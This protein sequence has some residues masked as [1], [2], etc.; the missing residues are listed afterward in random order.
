[1]RSR[2]SAPCF[3]PNLN[4]TNAI[5]ELA[6]MGK[7]NWFFGA[8]IFPMTGASMSAAPRTVARA[9]RR[10]SVRTKT[11][12]AVRRTRPACIIG[13]WELGGIAGRRRVG[14]ETASMA[15]IAI[16]GE[17]VAIVLE[18]IDGSLPSVAVL[19]F[20]RLIAA[21]R[22]RNERSAT[23]ATRP[24]SRDCSCTKKGFTFSGTR[25]ASRCG[26]SR[27]HDFHQIRPR[28]AR[29]HADCCDERGRRGRHA[30]A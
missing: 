29:T 26:L 5:G 18:E 11:G 10:G 16:A 7:T 30:V 15:Y 25:A 4:A 27:C 22:S 23:R 28:P 20:G 12:T 1:M 21:P 2:P 13:D 8:A 17:R 14:G 9:R 24:T 19:D 6:A 3:P